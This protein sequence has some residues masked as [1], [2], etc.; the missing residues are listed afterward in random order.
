MS[1]LEGAGATVDGPAS[2]ATVAEGAAVSDVEVVR[3]GSAEVA[4]TSTDG[5]LAGLSTLLDVAS[6]TIGNSPAD[7]FAGASSGAEVAG[8][9]VA[10][11]DE[12]ASGL[13]Q[14]ITSSTSSSSAA[15]GRALVLAEESSGSSRLPPR[16]ALDVRPSRS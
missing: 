1:R 2:L 9:V 12:D 10:D 8:G 14:P 11:D 4:A 15:P 16:L 3:L 13:L 7:A 6:V 5:S